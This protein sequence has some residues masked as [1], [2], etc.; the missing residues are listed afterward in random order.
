MKKQ[1][2]TVKKKPYVNRD[3][4]IVTRREHFRGVVWHREKAGGFHQYT[5]IG[6]V[7]TDEPIDVGTT[8]SD[9]YIDGETGGAVLDALAKL[10]EYNAPSR[11]GD[12]SSILMAMGRCNPATDGKCKVK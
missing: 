2:V 9:R 8:G 1:A 7:V 11:F 3:G 4:E 5:V 6:I 12:A 10:D